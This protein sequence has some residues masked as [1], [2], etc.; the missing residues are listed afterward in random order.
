MNDFEATLEALVQNA[1]VDAADWDDVLTRAHRG[2]ARRVAV[3]ASAAVLAVAIAAAPAF[4]ISD[5]LVD[6]FSGTPVAA[7]QLS[8]EQA[9]ALGAMASG[10]SPRLP[11]STEE[12][13]ARFGASALRQ[14][15]VR[16]GNAFFVANLRRGGLCVSVTP[17]GSAEV[18]GSITC[19]PDFPSSSRLLLDQSRFS[20]SIS[21]PRLERLQGFAAN[22]VASVGIITATGAVTSVTPVVDN[23][24]SRVSDL[25]TEQT[26]PDKIIALD[27]NGDQIDAES[28]RR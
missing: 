5:R 2:E 12:E 23:V 10:V 27:A 9:H 11:A 21:N 8:P 17:A 6:L 18:L 26:S 28:Q 14:I 7:D 4:G 24:Y 25:P 16:D 1:R 15:A 13:L 22:G 19:S 3:L 20:G